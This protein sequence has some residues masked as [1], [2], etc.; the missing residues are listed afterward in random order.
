MYLI[1][2]D[3]TSKIHFAV[4]DKAQS[5]SYNIRQ[6]LSSHLSVLEPTFVSKPP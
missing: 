6:K 4:F 3:V 2:F 1:Q 5:K